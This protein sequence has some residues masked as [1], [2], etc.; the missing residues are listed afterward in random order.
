MPNRPRILIL[1]SQGLLGRGL[2]LALQSRCDTL[3]PPE[4]EANVTRPDALIRLFETLEPDAVLNCAGFLNVDR[5][6]K[7]P[8]SS[9]RIN[10]AGAINAARSIAFLPPGRRP[11]LFQFS[12]DFVFDGTV[13]HY[14]ETAL[15]RPLSYYGV[16]KLLADEFM[17]AGPLSDFYI[18]RMSGLLS[19]VPGKDYF[20]K[21]MIA[22]SNERPFLQ[23][24][25]DLTISC[26]TVE[27]LAD[28]ILAL[29]ASRP[30]PGLYNAVCAGRATW[31][32][33]LTTAFEVLGIDY[34]VKAA[35]ID[36][37]P[38][39]QIR[40]RTSDLDISKITAATGLK[41][42]EW[43]DAVA[44]HVRAHYDEYKTIRTGK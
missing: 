17:L 29:L 18:L 23:V 41:I 5:C 28:F 36:T 13:G 10:A 16:H 11:V 24:V 4:S 7:E 22:L 20:I 34:E 8:A 30:R 38:N 25:D 3:A 32:A 26:V 42:P 39:A 2:A 33:M 14:D 9:Y 27:V 37:M 44:S 1:G 12:S 19:C 31:H 43:R 35:S 40:P 6:E 15:A 21:R